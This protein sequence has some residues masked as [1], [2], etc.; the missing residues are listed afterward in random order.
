MIAKL[1]G[2]LESFRDNA[3]IIDVSGVGYLVFMSSPTRTGLG[4][5]GNKVSLFIETHIR[6]DHIHLFGF[7]TE[8]ER[9]SFQILQTVQG[10][11]SKASLSILSV[12]T[13]NEMA[14]AITTKDKD[15]L[16]RADGVGPKLAGRIVN[17]LNGRLI[18]GAMDV[19]SD[20]KNL[21]SSMLNSHHADHGDMA[22][23]VSA[24]MNL[25]YSR[26]DANVAVAS[27][28]KALG[29]GA[30]LDQIISMSLKELAP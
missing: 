7:I 23:A 1:K 12:M 29:T 20:F 18:H 17:E 22:D 8:Q 5:I 9:K 28:N 15:I 19:S 30:K 6:E 26:S 13:P 14:Q 21:D 24:L 11:G 16:T 2:I 25:G 4:S 3:A 10:V 27:A